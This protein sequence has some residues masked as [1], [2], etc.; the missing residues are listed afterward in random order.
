MATS[1]RQRKAMRQAKAGYFT[2]SCA[3]RLIRAEKLQNNGKFLEPINTDLR[4]SKRHAG[5][6]TFVEHPIGHLA[7][8]P[9]PLLRVDALQ[10]LAA[11]ERC[12]LK[13]SSKKGMPRI[14]NH[15]ASKTVCR[16]SR[17]GLASSGKQKLFRRKDPAQASREPVRPGHRHHV[18]NRPAWLPPLPARLPEPRSCRRLHGPQDIPQPDNVNA[19]FGTY[20]RSSDLDHDQSTISHSTRRV[21]FALGGNHRHKHRRRRINRQCQ[22]ASARCL[23]PCKRM[24]WCDLVPTGNF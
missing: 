10:I 17:V 6:V 2:G 19:G 18:G 12:D 3:R 16:M 14:C 13:R 5:T 21:R 1:F 23:A 9:T 22:P 24:L 4:R 8:K 11:S 7:A 15:R 20:Q